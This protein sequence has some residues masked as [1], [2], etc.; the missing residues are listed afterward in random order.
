MDE[1]NEIS[2]KY[3]KDIEMLN[4]LLVV[5]TGSF[6]NTYHRST[7][8]EHKSPYASNIAWM[9]H[10]DTITYTGNAIYHTEG[11]HSYT[12]ND[13]ASFGSAPGRL[14]ENIS[15]TGVSASDFRGIP[16]GKAV[17]DSFSADC[18]SDGKSA[19][20]IDSCSSEHPCNQCPDPTDNCKCPQDKI[21]QGLCG[22][23]P[24][25]YTAAKKS[26]CEGAGDIW[27]PDCNNLH[28]IF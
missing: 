27:C 1:I 25:C 7:K 10:H 23:A 24:G 12:C 8:K 16:I 6:E 9:S 28:S 13:Y 21:D 14:F 17:L 20:W 18:C 3:N 2:A 22:G 11:N 4:D 15:W 19:V 26:D 5:R